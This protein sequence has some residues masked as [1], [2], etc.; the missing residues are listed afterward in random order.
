MSEGGMMS[1]YDSEDNVGEP[2]EVETEEGSEEGE[3]CAEDL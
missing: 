2:D 3:G 1:D